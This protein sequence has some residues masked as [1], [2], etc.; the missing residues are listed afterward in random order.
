GF[1]QEELNRLLARFVIL[2]DQPFTVTEAT[3]FIELMCHGR[4]KRPEIPNADSI[5]RRIVKLYENEK[6]KIIA[7]VKH[8]G[9][10]LA[11]SILNVL[12]EFG[13]TNKLLAITTDNASNNGSLM[14][15]LSLR[16][17]QKNQIFIPDDQW[18]R[19]FAHILN[20]ACQSSLETL[21]VTSE[22]KARRNFDN[23][24]SSDELEDDIIPSTLSI[25]G[26]LKETVRKILKSELHRDSLKYFCQTLNVE[27]LELIKDVKVRWNSTYLM[28]QR[29]LHLR[30]PLDET[31]KRNATLTSYLLLESEWGLIQQ[32]V[33]F[34][35]VFFL[36][37]V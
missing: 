9:K 34:L 5:K 26:R 2:T 20:L 25:Y 12:N 14:T 19:C 22:D 6:A 4:V 8:S 32:F 31:V 29:C 36:K 37:N 23:N 24:D 21:K 35:K 28:L 30:K 1:D 11:T 10:D 7:K 16:L 17:A 3:S 13:I 15:E 18:V 27:P 33:D